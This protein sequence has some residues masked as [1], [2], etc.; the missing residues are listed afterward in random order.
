VREAVLPPAPCTSHGPY[1]PRARTSLQLTHIIAR[2]LLPLVK[3]HLLACARTDRVEAMEAPSAAVEGGASA[4][5]I[6]ARRR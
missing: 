6:D 4:S 2:L 3:V 1:P 5:P